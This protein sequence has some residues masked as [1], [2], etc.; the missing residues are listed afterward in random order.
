MESE[1]ELR[2][3]R[4]LARG[5][6]TRLL[7]E[8][9]EC[10]KSLEDDL[11][12]AIHHIEGH[13]AHMAEVQL[14]LDKLAVP[15]DSSHVQDMLDQVF[16][17]KRVLTRLE[18]GSAVTTA[19]G[20]G[21]GR[22]FKLDLKLPKFCGD[23][24]TWPEFWNLFKVS[25]HDN[26]LFSPVEKFVHLKAYLVGQAEVAVQGLPFTDQGYLKAVET[27]KERFDRP[28]LRRQVLI[29]RLLSTTP[30]H[31]DSDLVRLRRMVDGLIAEVRALETMDVLPDSYSVLLMPVLMSCIPEPW[32][33]EWLRCKPGSDTAEG[34][35]TVFLKFLQR[36]MSI[37][38]EAG[39]RKKVIVEGFSA[40][41]PGKS[42]A[43]I[44]SVRKARSPDWVCS[45]C[46]IGKHGLSACS[47]YRCMTVPDRWRVVRQA[48]LCYQC[49]GPHI[50]RA[51]T[52]T[53]CPWC[54]GPHHSSLHPPPG[55]HADV[56]RGGMLSR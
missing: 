46:G 19:S 24:E 33:I 28:D 53:Q 5:K 29:Q 41:A 49:L 26:Q 45:A 54:G 52:S 43:S 38:E 3:K 48:R 10:D 2:Q 44:L 36:E 7:R 51:C 21:T 22:K 32:K 31:S 39:A 47:A 23:Y 55:E 15:D 12:L 42:T 18:R 4:T 13:I 35:L 9:T 37:R 56:P 14:E 6:A 34:E 20:S 1:S 40:A 17:A 27:L 16:K 8:L 30:V 50:L 25:V 11:A